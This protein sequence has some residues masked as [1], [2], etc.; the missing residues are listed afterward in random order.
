MD[1]LHSQ[2]FTF[3]TVYDF[4]KLSGINWVFEV[5]ILFILNQIKH[6]KI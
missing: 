2:D 1:I 3:F 5:D 4:L 6:F